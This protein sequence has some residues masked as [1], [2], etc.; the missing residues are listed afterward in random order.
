VA[1]IYSISTQLRRLAFKM[2]HSTTILLPAWREMLKGMG[3]PVHLMPCNVPT[4]W[5]SSA[6]MV[7]FALEYHE[8]LNAMMQKRDL[9]LRSLELSDEEWRALKELHAVLKILKDTTMFFLCTSP[10]LVT[11]IPTM[12]HINKVFTTCS[13]DPTYSPPSVKA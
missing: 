10:N 12:D 9:G 3:M 1:V 8:P 11:V 13:L 7:E 6:D 5:N 2:I 4:W